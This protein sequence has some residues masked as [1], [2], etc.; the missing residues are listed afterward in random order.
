MLPF[1]LQ[2]GLWMLRDSF[3]KFKFGITIAV[4]FGFAGA[5]L[6]VGALIVLYRASS[7]LDGAG[8]IVVI[9]PLSLTF[10]RATFFYLS[11]A[12][13]LTMVGLSAALIYF[14]RLRSVVYW[15]RYQLALNKQILDATLQAVSEARVDGSRLKWQSD[16]KAVMLGSVRRLS[17]V[18]RKLILSVEAAVKFFLFLGF[19][20]YVS[21][22]LTLLLFLG[23]SV[24]TLISTLKFGR[25]SS[26]QM[27]ALQARNSD[28]S[29]QWQELARAAF[30]GT[31]V[32]TDE[33]DREGSPV[34]VYLTT[35]QAR[36]ID[37][38]NSHLTARVTTVV[39]LLL[40]LITF[41][42]AALNG[43]LPWPDLVAALIA[44]VMTM[45]SLAV[46]A[47]TLAVFGRFYPEIDRYRGL[48]KSLTDARNHEHYEQ[49]NASVGISSGDFEDDEY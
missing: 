42:G 46:L 29:K 25:N 9:E 21:P 1:F 35:F 8:E 49:M 22:T 10:E 17:I 44:I 4:L 45:T 19:S 40:T 36:F 6:Q 33:I 12:A 5:S 34:N 48:L 43:E 18:F 20:L 2:N 11:G 3:G 26:K 30:S 27:R 37:V 14:F 23:A 47:G 32:A 7:L 28:A 41:G 38:E 15:R 13:I 24:V 31:S 39:L 16:Y